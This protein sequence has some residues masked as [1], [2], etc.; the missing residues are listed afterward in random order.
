MKETVTITLKPEQ[1]KDNKLIEKLLLSQLK[2]RGSRRS[3]V[4]IKRS[5]DARHG[6]VKLHLKYDVYIDEEPPSKESSLPVWKRL[7]ENIL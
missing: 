5:V 7:M 4:F 3:F 6:Q 2:N 1:E